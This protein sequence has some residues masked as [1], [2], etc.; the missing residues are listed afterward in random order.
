MSD[1]IPDYITDPDYH[2]AYCPVCDHAPTFRRHHLSKY[3]RD[4]R[5]VMTCV[6]GAV[7]TTVR[8]TERD[9]C[10]VRPWYIARSWR[11]QFYGP[12]GLR[13]YMA[14]VCIGPY[15]VSQHVSDMLDVIPIDWK[16]RTR[17]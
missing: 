1:Y 3:M 6:C 10:E 8:R 4:Y 17:A 7:R 9:R 5:N 15:P 11:R 12:K 14:G 2:W 13:E 16:V